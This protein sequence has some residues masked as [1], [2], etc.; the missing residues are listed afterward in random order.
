MTKTNYTDRSEED[1]LDSSP[2]FCSQI[3]ELKYQSDRHL[4]RHLKEKKTW[5]KD[6]LSIDTVM[7]SRAIPGQLFA[8]ATWAEGRFFHDTSVLAEKAPIKLLKY[9]E[10]NVQF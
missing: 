9:Y 8:L 4:S 7:R 1:Q 3:N 5:E 2:A 6:I 10:A